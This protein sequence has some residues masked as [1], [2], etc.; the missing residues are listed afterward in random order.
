MK[1]RK[2][3]QRATTP[4]QRLAVYLTKKYG[5]SPESLKNLTDEGLCEQLVAFGG[6]VGVLFLIMKFGYGITKAQDMIEYIND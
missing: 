2:Q 1:Q 3:A 4:K 6:D 5:C